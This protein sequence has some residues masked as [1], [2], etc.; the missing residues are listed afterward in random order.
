M[1][2]PNCNSEIRNENINIHRDIAQCHS[3]ESIFKVS[4]QIDTGVD[5]TF[6]I[7][8][9]PSGAWIEKYKD[10]VVIGA[11]TRSPI[12]FFLVPFMLVWSGGSLGGIYGTQIIT[13]QFS[14]FQSLFGIP[15]LLGSVL[16][17]SIALMAIFGKVELKLDKRGGK[18][19]TV[20]GMLGIT[21]KFNWANVSNILEN[22][23]NLR[24]SGSEGLALSIEGKSRIS[25]G[26]SL[27][28]KRRYYLLNA[29]KQCKFEIKQ[30]NS[31]H[32]I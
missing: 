15:F 9:P 4:E 3:C 25:F 19:F 12:A 2:C 32:R 17:W 21:E 22:T 30:R 6:D 29:L 5:S 13:G 10:E 31:L 20:I 28:S 7:D 8:S 16:F 23:T 24:F 11:T 1:E 18:V 26:R 14:L 27:K